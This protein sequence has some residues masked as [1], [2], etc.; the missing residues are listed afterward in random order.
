MPRGVMDKAARRRLARELDESKA[1]Q[2]VAAEDPR[3]AIEALVRGG[4]GRE[5]A[6]DP[7]ARDTRTER[8]FRPM[9]RLQA[10]LR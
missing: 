2:V 4:E 6:G 10:V 9:P 7:V 8:A 5:A 3:A 1:R